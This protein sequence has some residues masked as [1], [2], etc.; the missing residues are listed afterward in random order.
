MLTRGERL[1]NVRRA[2]A[3]RGGDSAAGKKIVLLDD[4]LTTGATTSACAR[5]LMAAQ[6]EKVCVWTVARGLLN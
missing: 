1:A 4:V 3:L 2:F 6:A 5:L